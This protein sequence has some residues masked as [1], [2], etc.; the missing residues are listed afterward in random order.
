MSVS[1]EEVRRHQ[2]QFV[3]NINGLTKSWLQTG[4]EEK[5]STEEVVDG[6]VFSILSHID[7]WHS[8]YS[9]EVDDIDLAGSLHEIWSIRNK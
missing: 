9:N 4:K 3:R 7:S 6:V 2:D 1:E 8:L 5:M